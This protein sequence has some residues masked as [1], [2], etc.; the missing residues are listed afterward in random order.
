MDKREKARKRFD[1]K[2]QKYFGYDH[3]K[4]K[5]FEIIYEILENKR[6]VCGILATGY[7]KSI[8]Y[9]LPF[10]IKRECVIVVSPLIS[11]MED[12]KHSMEKRNIPVCCLNSATEYRNM[13][14]GKLLQ[15][16]FKIVYMT[17]EFMVNSQTFLEELSE[18]G[19]ACV[20]IDESHCISQWGFDFREEYRQ[21]HLIKEWIPDVPVLAL[22]ATATSR[23]IQDI[24]DSLLLDDPVIVKS[25]FDRPN[26]YIEVNRKS[27]DPIDDIA[28]Y[29][30]KYKDD[31][32]IIYAKTRRETRELAER[33]NNELGIKAAAYNGEMTTDKRE[34]VQKKFIEGKINCMV[35]TIAFGMGIDQ[36]VH[37]V[38]NYGCSKSIESYYQEI[39]RAGRDGKPSE[40]ITFFSAKDFSTNRYFLKEIT[41]RDE[42]KRR[43]EEII[44]IEKYLYATTCRRKI[45]LEHLEEEDEIKC[46]NCDN[47]L[48]ENKSEQRD[49][50]E[51]AFYLLKSVFV[52]KRGMGA[53]KAIKML[54]G[55]KSKDMTPNFRKKSSYGKGINWSDKWWKEFIRFMINYGFLKEQSVTSGYGC[56]L[57][58]TSQGYDWYKTAKN[59]KKK[60]EGF[61]LKCKLLVEV[62]EELIE[63][64][65]KNKRKIKMKSPKIK[66]DTELKSFTPTKK[67]SYDLFVS[68]LTIEE[69]ALARSIQEKTVEDHLCAAFR[70]GL[71][72]DLADA[73]YTDKVYQKIK[74]HI[75][76]KSI[77]TSML[78][79]IKRGL[80]SSITYFH[81]KLALIQMDRDGI[82]IKSKSKSV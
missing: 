65:P 30:G 1:K 20:A 46:G 18:R 11:L 64:E 39:G 16:E 15:G 76:G 51:P 45:L 74:K 79:Y 56:I 70:H 55:S 8:C 25:S 33:I 27:H 29:L 23:V 28:P 9:Q 80:P 68:G 58:L 47:C 12:Q 61:D 37:L 5:Q 34:K 3:L 44:K 82:Q 19:I 4:E 48:C 52:I 43:E 49:I 7:G 67:E 6:D 26:L 59:E 35:A 54:R 13:V 2:L 10:L 78:R 73:G 36:D 75:T 77:N 32:T 60:I 31:F 42:K 72:M 69:I 17:P 22:T 63:L 53:T 50:T 40:C 21:L 24:C 66:I 62:P 41:D 57:K 14:K 71:E 38:I 81:I